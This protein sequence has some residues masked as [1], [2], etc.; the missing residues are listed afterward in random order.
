MSFSRVDELEWM[1]I[2][3]VILR[4]DVNYINSALG[5]ICFTRSNIFIIY[6]CDNSFSVCVCVWADCHFVPVSRCMMR[7]MLEMERLSS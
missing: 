2:M 7:S 4:S 6:E 3:C 1:C 5:I